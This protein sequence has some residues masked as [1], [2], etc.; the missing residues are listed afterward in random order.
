[1][2]GVK[3]NVRYDPSPEEKLSSLGRVQ[4]IKSGR[5]KVQGI[6][7]IRFGES[8]VDVVATTLKWPIPRPWREAVVRFLFVEGAQR[9]KALMKHHM[10]SVYFELQQVPS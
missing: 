9:P 2:N 3:I 1:M 8:K 4:R 5:C 6:W 10:L 7:D